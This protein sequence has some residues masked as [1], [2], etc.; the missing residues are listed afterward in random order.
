MDNYN[1]I[2]NYVIGSSLD[3]KQRLE[4]KETKTHVGPRDISKYLTNFK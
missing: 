4:W 3:S 1:D 2:K